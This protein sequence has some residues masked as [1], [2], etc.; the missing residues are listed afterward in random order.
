MRLS[1][2]LL[3]LN[4]H[5]SSALKI[6][7]MTCFHRQVNIPSQSNGLQ[8][9]D[10]CALCLFFILN[11]VHREELNFDLCYRSAFQND[12]SVLEPENGSF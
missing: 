1:N 4:V 6:A 2:W 12:R 10:I 5:V 9:H 7:G 11:L 8:G 3:P